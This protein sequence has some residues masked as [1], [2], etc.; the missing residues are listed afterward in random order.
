[1]TKE[2]ITHENQDEDAWVCICGNTPDSDGFYPCDVKGKEIEPDKT[3][4]WNGLYLCHR[5]SRVIDQHNLRVISD[6]NTNR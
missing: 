1:M 3:S 5:C 6:L 2:F 4:G